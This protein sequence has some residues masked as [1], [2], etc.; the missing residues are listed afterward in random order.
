MDFFGFLPFSAL[1]IIFHMFVSSLPPSK[2]VCSYTEKRGTS[3]KGVSDLTDV[4]VSL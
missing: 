4:C 3:E 2:G 1:L